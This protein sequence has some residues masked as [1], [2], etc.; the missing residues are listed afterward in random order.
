MTASRLSHPPRT[1]PACR[2]INSLHVQSRGSRGPGKAAGKA[3]A[4][5]HGCIQRPAQLPAH[6]DTSQATYPHPNS[7]STHPPTHRSGMLISSST[8]QG[9][10]TWPLQHRKQQAAAYRWSDIRQRGY[11]ASGH[12]TAGPADAGKRW[13]RQR[14][15]RRQ[16]LDQQRHRQQPKASRGPRPPA[17]PDAEQLGSRVVGAPQA[18]IPLQAGQVGG[19]VVDRPASKLLCTCTPGPSPDAAT[20]APR[21]RAA[22]VHRTPSMPRRRTVT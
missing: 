2:S 7:L 10:F 3:R 21:A 4:R 16:Q 11:S 6:P 20:A 5:L 22:P 14:C 19:R 13:R 18:S 17:P 9:R 15:Q 1:P 12:S 8:V